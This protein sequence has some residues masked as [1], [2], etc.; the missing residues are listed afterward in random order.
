MNNNMIDPTCAVAVA[1]PRGSYRGAPGTPVLDLLNKDSRDLAGD[2]GF[3]LSRKG[4]MSVTPHRD[5]SF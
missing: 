2:S 4:G 3:V 5:H 1:G